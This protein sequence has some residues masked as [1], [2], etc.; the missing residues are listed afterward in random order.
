MNSLLAILN[1]RKHDS[2][3]SV[4]ARYFLQH[5]DRLHDLNVYDVANECFTSRSGIRRFCQSIGLDNFKDLKS[6]T[7]EWDRHRNLYTDYAS[8]PNYRAYLSATITDMMRQIDDTVDDVILDGFAQLIYEAHSVLV[9]TSDFSSA[10][11]SQFQHAMVYLHKVVNVITDTSGDLAQMDALEEDDLLV[12]IS[13]HGNYARAVLSSFESCRAIRAL[14]TVDA[15]PDLDGAYDYAMRLT[16]K[17]Q[18]P[19]RTVFAQY[20]IAYFLDLLYNRYL[21]VCKEAEEQDWGKGLA[22]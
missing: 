14:V 1:S 7:W 3:D 10:A 22:R 6:Y 8:H 20:G 4:L 2:L 17:R 5:F 9:V 18:E 15:S 21:V 13:E 12:V 16:A 19:G 11:V